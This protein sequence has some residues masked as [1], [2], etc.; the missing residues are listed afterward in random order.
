MPRVEFRRLGRVALYG[1]LTCGFGLAMLAPGKGDEA[2]PSAMDETWP[3]VGRKIVARYLDSLPQEVPETALRELEG[4]KPVELKQVL[5]W[6]PV[7][8]EQRPLALVD[9]GLAQDGALFA[10]LL[11]ASLTGY[12]APPVVEL[13]RLMQQLPL[14]TDAPLRLH[15]LVACARLAAVENATRVELELL[16]GAARHPQADWGQ[17][18]VLVESA[19]EA[20]DTAAALEVLQDWLDD[21]PERASAVEQRR[22]RAAMARLLLVEHRSE[23][24]WAVLQPVFSGGTELEPELLEVAWSAAAAAG[25]TASMAGPLEAVLQDQ[26]WHRKHWRELADAPTATPEYVTGLRRL[27]TACQAAGDEKRALEMHLHL[28]WLES[29]RHL[30]PVLPVAVGMERLEEVLDLLDRLD[31]ER[32]DLAGARALDLARYAWEQ[33]QTESARQ[34]LEG[35]LARQPQDLACTRLLLRLRAA[36]LPPMQAVLLWRQHLS[37][38][39]SDLEAHRQIV[40]LWQQ[41]DQPRAAVN[42]LLA[43]PAEAWGP[44][45]RVELAAAAITARHA[46]ALRVALERLRAA[47]EELPAELVGAGEEL[48]AMSQRQA[49]RE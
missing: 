6:L 49:S 45:L 26:P 23:Q 2:R 38:H 16:A 5:D 29:P 9:T 17:V 19:I 7:A 35:R 48:L 22:A 20:R 1:S 40:A 13:P 4:L 43:L 34:L 18:G 46:P 21:P 27:A 41:A 24:A 15:L 39:A 25:Q 44:A 37:R 11:E 28:A 31:E 10:A 36:S 32:P 30:L 14:P 3:R 33:G 47:G 12:G 42:H 8:V